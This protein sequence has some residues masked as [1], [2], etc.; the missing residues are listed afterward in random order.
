MAVGVCVLYSLSMNNVYSRMLCAPVLL[1]AELA[2]AGD[3]GLCNDLFVTDDDVLD[4]CVVGDTAYLAMSGAGF[5]IL[6]ISDP[7]QAM[8]LGEVRTTNGTMQLDVAGNIVYLADGHNGLKCV[9]VSDPTNPVVVGTL[10]FPNFVDGVLVRD[11]VAYLTDGFIGGG[12]QVVDVSDPSAPALIGSLVTD[13]MAISMELEGDYLYLTEGPSGLKV[14]DVSDPSAPV[15]VGSRPNRGG[16]WTDSILVEGGYAYVNEH[17]WIVIY[18]LTDP[19]NPLEVET[20][21]MSLGLDISSFMIL[22]GTLWTTEFGHPGTLTGYTMWSATELV[23][24]PIEFELSGMPNKVL[25]AEDAILVAQSAF[26]IADVPPGEWNGVG[27]LNIITDL[28]GCDACPADLTLDGDLNFLDVSLFLSDFAGSRPS[29]DFTQD[30]LFN[31]LD[32]S[33]FLAAFAEGCP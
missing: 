29:A 18:D 16:A 28:T 5:Q 3:G 15:V 12:L 4:V 13:G 30:G 31:F 24:T 2:L 1:I 32:V 10:D 20:Y 9:D 14:I 23:E 26:N 6:D 11:G 19:T 27:G 8:V 17:N 33:A 25:F 7:G 22:F 21:P